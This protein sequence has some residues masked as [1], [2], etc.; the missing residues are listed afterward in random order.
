MIDNYLTLDF[1]HCDGSSY[2]DRN[3]KFYTYLCMTKVFLD[4]K[5]YTYLCMTK[6]F[7][8]F[9]S[10]MPYFS[11][12]IDCFPCFLYPTVKYFGLENKNK[13]LATNNFGSILNFS[14]YS[15]IKSCT[16]RFYFCEYSSIANQ[17]LGKRSY[18]DKLSHIWWVQ[19][20]TNNESKK[21]GVTFVLRIRL[22]LFLWNTRI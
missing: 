8:D 18:Y 3:T 13:K 10:I 9:N 20:P 15:K 1:L 22:F 16:I 5:F 14:I 12:R 21:Y 17:M 7:L 6:V 11:N 4:T 2:E 19:I